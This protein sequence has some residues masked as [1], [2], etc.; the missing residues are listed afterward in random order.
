MTAEGGK[1]RV[2]LE[3]LAKAEDMRKYVE[4]HPFGQEAI[5]ETSESWNFYCQVIE[6]LQDKAMFD[7]NRK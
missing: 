2:F 6:S 1:L 3:G 4:E 7:L 5:S